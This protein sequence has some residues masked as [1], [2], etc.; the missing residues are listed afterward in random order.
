MDKDRK[1]KIESA[2]LTA[3]IMALLLLM[4]WYVAIDAPRETEEEGVEVAFGDS[5]D[6]GGSE[7]EAIPMP[8][9]PV[10]QAPPPTPQAPSEND[11]VVQDDEESLALAKQREEERK[12]R[13]EQE[14]LIRKQR[15]EQARL[16]AEQRAEQQRIAEEQ[17]RKAA[18]EQAKRDN[19]NNLMAGMFGN[20]QQGAQ[21][22]G[23][24][25]GASQQGSNNP[26]GHGTI[27]GNSWSLAGRSM[28]KMP[29]PSTQFNQEG[30][31]VVNIQVNSEGKVMSATV[32]EGTTVSDY[33][34]RQVALEAARKAEFS[35]SE[36]R[37][38]VGTITYTFKL[39]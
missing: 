13:A 35:P 24:T 1:A 31:V 27:G 14:E 19:A 34:T 16:E 2:L 12:K 22:S 37:I 30:K 5:E 29:K 33:Q 18:E 4:M 21:G 3:L 32:G 6:G 11:L 38:Q 26:V 15:E 23:T 9:E 28:K 39:N 7:P 20:N 8:A 36:N 10:T 17:A 25:Q